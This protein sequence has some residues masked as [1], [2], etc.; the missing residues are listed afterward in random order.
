MKVAILMPLGTQRGGGELM[1]WQLLT[2]GRNAGVEWMV[3]FFEEGHLVD[4]VR[5]LGIETHVIHPG[6]LR[7]VHRFMGA[8]RT[9]A[10]LVQK[11]SADLIFS[12]SAKP[13]FYGSVAGLL[14][15][16][17][18]AW[19]QLGFPVG[20][21]LSL[22]D[23]VATALPAKGIFTLSEISTKGQ[24]ALWPTR[25]T[26]LVYP[27]AELSR[28]DP[29]T[30][31]T[32]MEAREDLGLPPSGPLIGTVG[33]LQHWKG[34]HTL[35]RAMPRVR[36]THPDA[37]CVIVGGRHDL[38]PDYADRLDRIVEELNLAP[39]VTFAGF[40]RNVPEWMQAMDVFI[41]ASDNE[42]FGIVIV[43]A[44][45]LGK[46]VVVGSEGGPQEI[47]TEGKNGHFAP[48]DA[49]DRLAEKVCRYLDDPDHA[50]SMG[51]A[52]RRRAQFFSPERYANRFLDALYTM[53]NA[54]PSA[55]TT[56]RSSPHDPLSITN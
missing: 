15:G 27:S 53:M 6:R 54:R 12:W 8:V 3:I 35:L 30:L 41:H 47:V 56:R 33:R 45:A 21:H 49:P 24:E 20:R 37:H 44:M 39:H 1:L 50:A 46:P 31:P 13:H 40:Q 14:A 52:A 22:I 5:A 19:Y 28:F 2:H 25:P 38:E 29:S 10:K 7:H 34:M 55:D 51:A 36:A 43:E 17:P 32:P 26:H 11:G 42:P 18:A 48:F 9:I 16:L 23:H 4:D